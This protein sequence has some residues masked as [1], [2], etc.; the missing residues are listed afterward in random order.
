MHDVKLIWLWENCKQSVAN[1]IACETERAAVERICGPE[2]S[3]G[4]SPRQKAEGSIDIGV[5]LGLWRFIGG[6]VIVAREQDDA[7]Y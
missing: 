3:S 7:A 1:E 6:P 5:Q 2:Q 4:R